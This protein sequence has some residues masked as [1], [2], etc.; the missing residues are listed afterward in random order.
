[1]N[2]HQHPTAKPE[3]E[4]API[5]RKIEWVNDASNIN[6]RRMYVD[7]QQWAK[8]YGWDKA[9]LDARC[10]ALEAAL[11]ASQPVPAVAGDMRPVEA[12]WSDGKTHAYVNMQAALSAEAKEWRRKIGLRIVSFTFLDFDTRPT[13]SADQSGAIGALVTDAHIGG[14]IAEAQRTTPDMVKQFRHVIDQ[15]LAAHAAS[16]GEGK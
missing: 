1:M 4:G 10:D 9:S 16:I 13:P 3:G 11:S 7:G 2:D 15:A 6:D 8:V 5:A 14:W 12:T